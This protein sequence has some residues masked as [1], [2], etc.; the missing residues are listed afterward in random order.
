M[1][2]KPKAIKTWE[3][4]TVQMPLSANLTKPGFDW[5][6]HNYDESTGL[7]IEK[8]GYAYSDEGY[9]A[10]TEG[11]SKIEIHEGTKV[12]QNLFRVRIE[13][14]KDVE[15]EF[16][17]AME[18]MGHKAEVALSLP[19]ESAWKKWSLLRLALAKEGWVHELKG[20]KNIYDEAWLDQ[21]LA[22]HPE[23]DGI[24]DSMELA[25]TFDGHA[26][27]VMKDPKPYRD[28]GWKCSYR[29]DKDLNSLYLQ[30]SQG[31]GWASRKQRGCM[32][33]GQIAKGG[34]GWSAGDDIESGGADG[35]FFRIANSWSAVDGNYGIV[36]HPRAFLRTDWRRYTSDAYGNITN[37][38]SG[39]HAGS[40]GGLS[41]LHTVGTEVCFTGGAPLK[42]IMCVTVPNASSKEKLE[43]MLAK[44]GITEIN[45]VP[46]ADFVLVGAHDL[47]NRIHPSLRPGEEWQK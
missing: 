5:P 33:T 34:T 13:D 9:K 11:G 26:T 2:S 18:K 31:V 15:A 32:G 6:L 22:K 12:F 27:W 41:D 28:A 10:S 21:E 25:Q 45:G 3:A 35:N 7:H 20:D 46:V 4:G 29:H 8:G 39:S 14:G 43:K 42:D 36:Q 37:V 16:G 30:L 38:G 23:T 47:E 1:A 40:P 17:A 44:D 24:L 19:N